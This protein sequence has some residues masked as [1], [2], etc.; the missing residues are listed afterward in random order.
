MKPDIAT[1]LIELLCSPNRGISHAAF[2]DGCDKVCFNAF[3][4][5]I[6]EAYSSVENCWCALQMPH[7]PR[8]GLLL[9]MLQKC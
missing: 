8:L 1:P 5:Y 2:C 3:I 7:L 4:S 6:S 9:R